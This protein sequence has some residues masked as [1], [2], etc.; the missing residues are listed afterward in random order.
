MHSKDSF[1]TV[2]IMLKTKNILKPFNDVYNFER[3]PNRR[4]AS[5]LDSIAVQRNTW[6]F[7]VESV[8]EYCRINF[9]LFGQSKPVSHF[10]NP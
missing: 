5:A 7:A 1:K 9:D 3:G 4:S 2:F 10:K 8:L 6:S